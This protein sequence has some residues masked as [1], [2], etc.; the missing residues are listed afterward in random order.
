MAGSTRG[1][2]SLTTLLLNNNYLSG[3]VSMGF[4]GKSS[5]LRKNLVTLR[6]DH[7]KL[8][9]NLQPFFPTSTSFEGN[10]QLLRI[11]GNWWPSLRVLRLGSNAFTGLIPQDIG[12]LCPRLEV[13]SLENNK[14][15]GPLP[16]SVA[17]HCR[18]LRALVLS[19]NRECVGTIP[20]AWLRAFRCQYDI[21]FYKSNSTVQRTPTSII[22]ALRRGE[23]RHDRRKSTKWSPEAQKQRFCGNEKC[24]GAPNQCYPGGCG[25]W[26]APFQCLLLLG[27]EGLDGQNKSKKFPVE[28]RFGGIAAL[29]DA[30]PRCTIYVEPLRRNDGPNDGDV[31]NDDGNGRQSTMAEKDETPSSASEVKKCVRQWRK[32]IEDR[33][34]RIAA[35]GDRQDQSD[36]A[37]E[38]AF[39]LAIAHELGLFGLEKDD[40]EAMKLYSELAE[41]PAVAPTADILTSDTDALTKKQMSL[42]SA[43]AANSDLAKSEWNRLRLKILSSDSKILKS[44]AKPYSEAAKDNGIGEGPLEMENGGAVRVKVTPSPYMSTFST[45]IHSTHLDSAFVY[46]REK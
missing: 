39:E 6:L 17:T 2:V 25:G 16:N 45:A 46:E 18:A 44:S 31:T 32:T 38:A 4:A 37:C 21:D 35:G 43:L 9:G 1:L 26:V 14:L 19:R 28:Q 30:I 40:K 15:R 36:G 29:R 10:N 12:K 8:S 27:L 20:D 41:D 42:P 13:L 22:Y 23:Q 24:L 34:D 7:N 5:L 11:K 33:R 3:S